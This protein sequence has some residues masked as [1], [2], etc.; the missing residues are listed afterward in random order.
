MQHGFIKTAA[1]TPDIR[2]ADCEYNVMSAIGLMRAA[3][4]KGSRAAGSSG[5]LPHGL[6]LRRAVPAKPAAAGRGRGAL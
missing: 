6:Y 3:I 2:V 5:A 1:A 4:R